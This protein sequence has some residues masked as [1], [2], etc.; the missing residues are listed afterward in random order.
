MFYR[1]GQFVFLTFP[2]GLNGLVENQYANI[3]NADLCEFER[4]A[5]CLSFRP[6]VFDFYYNEHPQQGKPWKAISRED[7]AKV[8]LDPAIEQQTVAV[9]SWMRI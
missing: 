3:T 2:F 4:L 5:E 7:A 8:P 9:C 6:L 1:A